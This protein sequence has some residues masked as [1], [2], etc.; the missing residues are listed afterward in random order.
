M[1]EINIVKVIEY[2]I[3]KNEIYIEKF[4]MDCLSILSMIQGVKGQVEPI[5]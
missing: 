4:E 5:N 2:L 1:S 3:I